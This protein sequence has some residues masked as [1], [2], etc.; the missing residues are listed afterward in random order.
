MTQGKLINQYL[1][2]RSIGEGPYSKIKLMRNIQDG[3]LYA[4]KKYNLFILKK[5]NKLMKK[6]KGQGIQLVI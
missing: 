4:M 5:K 6:E 3:L 2:I 1:K